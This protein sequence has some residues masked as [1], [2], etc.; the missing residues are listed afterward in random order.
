MLLDTSYSVRP[1]AQA[2][3]KLARLR[4]DLIKQYPQVGPIFA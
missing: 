3:P 4:S 2:P 1:G